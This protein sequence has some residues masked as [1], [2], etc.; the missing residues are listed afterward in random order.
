MLRTQLSARLSARPF[1]AS[2]RRLS[3]SYIP[4]PEYTAEPKYPAIFDPSPAADEMRKEEKWHDWLKS[5]ST[6]EEKLFE[7]N[8]P[9]RYGWHS[10]LLKET[11]TPYNLLP[12]A[13]FITRTSMIEEETLTQIP[14][15]SKID[16]LANQLLP[17]I[18][19]CI[20]DVIVFHDES[21]SIG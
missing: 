3:S 15:G 7:I 19:G 21:K 9:K 13:K 1:V 17:S 14:G 11:F 12:M 4:D 2:V 6:V 5:H 18:K 8:M 20:E 10:V 16:E